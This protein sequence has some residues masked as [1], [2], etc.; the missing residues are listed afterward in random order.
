[1]RNFSWL[2]ALA[3]ML[4]IHM[5]P[6]ARAQTATTDF[7]FTSGLES[8]TAPFTPYANLV[9]VDVSVDGAQPLPFALDT[10]IGQTV[11][12]SDVARALGIAVLVRH[13]GCGGRIANDL[14]LA[15]RGVR[16]Y[17][18]SADIA[19]LS[20][21]WPVLGV[22][23]DGIIGGD[24]LSRFVVRIDYAR[25]AV[26]LIDPA[27]YPPAERGRSI[28]IVIRDGEPFVACALG[29]NGK[30]PIVASLKIDTGSIDAVSLASSFVR[31]HGLFPAGAK[32]VA[33]PA[34][35]GVD[36]RGYARLAS[37]GFK[38]VTLTG[39]IVAY[40]ERT[41]AGAIGARILSRFTVDIDYA[42]K[43]LTLGPNG[44]VS[45]SF[46][47]DASGL[48]VVAAGDR[49]GAFRVAAVVPGSPAADAGL[50]AGDAVMSVDGRKTTAM[51]L[52]KLRRLLE[53]TGQTTRLGIVSAGK[54][55][56]VSIRLR[57][58]L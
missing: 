32:H 41:T 31:A 15:W 27:G 30:P 12:D 50:R 49:A 6:A 11:I 25:R 52:D 42:H 29:S 1:M 5:L 46:P 56:Q 3:A 18:E 44:T 47:F 20:A 9:I 24:V 55:K 8:A 51:S 54:P 23:I 39:P 33:V 2:V 10:G 26:T 38:G 22:R 14:T 53:Q 34:G 35:A 17:N 19:P 57:E 28:P 21:L 4:T 40:S 7:Q 43:Q 48:Y 37:I 58:L 36:A 13:G 45:S 16:V